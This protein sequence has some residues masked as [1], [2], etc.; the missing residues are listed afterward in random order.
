MIGKVKTKVEKNNN[1]SFLTS[2]GYLI[3]GVAIVDFASS[4]AG[5]NMTAFLG[6]A[7]KFS[8]IALGLLGGALIGAG[9]GDD[10]E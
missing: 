3:V 4:Y 2:I 8:A 1:V 6:E 5:Y 7:S 9:K 10:N